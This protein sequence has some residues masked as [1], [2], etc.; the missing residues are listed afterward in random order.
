M[1]TYCEK[2]NDSATDQVWL[3]CM[4][5]MDSKF[6]IIAMLSLSNLLIQILLKMFLIYITKHV[7]NVDKYEETSS[8]A[9][10][11][12]SFPHKCM[13]AFQIWACYHGHI[14]QYQI[15][16][17]TMLHKRPS[18]CISQIM[19]SIYYKPYHTYVCSSS[20]Y[21][22]KALLNPSLTKPHLHKRSHILSV[23]TLSDISVYSSSSLQ[24]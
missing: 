7:L 19:Y 3:Q 4:E 15:S 11:Y 24:N 10:R 13:L 17:D 18:I 12:N 16:H 2:Y 14:H 6:W 22:T 8:N 23:W 21:S 5:Q 1:D 20:S 9:F